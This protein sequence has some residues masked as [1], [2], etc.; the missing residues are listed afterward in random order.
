MSYKRIV[1]TRNRN[2]RSLR[3]YQNNGF[4]LPLKS[5]GKLKV[6]SY[7]LKK[8]I[9]ITVF[10]KM[11]TVMT[12]AILVSLTPPSELSSES[13]KLH[14][15]QRQE[16]AL[17]YGFPESEIQKFKE[18]FS[19]IIVHAEREQVSLPL[20]L[21]IIKS[22][23]NF[24]TEAVSSAGALGLMQLMPN[25]AR[26]EHRQF[27]TISPGDTFNPNDVLK[28]QMNIALG[29]QHIKRLDAIL[30][31][32][33]DPY[34]KRQVIIASYNAGLS[35]VKRAFKTRKNRDLVN[36]INLNGKKYFNRSR[37]ALP[38]ETRHYLKKVN[39]N[40][41]RYTTLLTPA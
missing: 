30:A 19:D 15:S 20:V 14:D 5:K 11:A 18:Y 12:I 32:V 23:S 41:K 39:K 36:L 33:K 1:K 25:T 10:Q 29:I 17:Y 26:A 2:D 4:S 22:E 8:K 6:R 24:D 21:A 38:G 37:S 16:L 9:G 40:Y 27:R 35:R 3:N 34:L 13:F 28:P 31:G 7:S